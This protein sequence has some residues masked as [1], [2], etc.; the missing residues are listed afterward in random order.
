[1]IEKSA[2]TAGTSAFSDERMPEPL[3]GVSLP[4]IGLRVG[5][6]VIVSCFIVTALMAQTEMLFDPGHVPFTL[7]YLKVSLIAI[8]LIAAI[9]R[10]SINNPRIAGVSLIFA[11]YLLLCG[12]YEYFS[13]DMLASDVILG[14]NSYYFLYFVVALALQFRL[15][16]PEKT[17]LRVVLLLGAACAIVALAQIATQSPVVPTD[18]VDQN[19]SVTAYKTSYSGMRV[20]S[21]FEEP[22][23]FGLFCVFM[24]GIF[25]ALCK[26]SA[27]RLIAVPMLLLSIFLCWESDARTELLALACVVATAW[28]IT[29][30]KKPGRT[31]FLPFMWLFAGVPIGVFAY[32]RSLTSGASS[33][34]ADTTSFTQRITEWSYYLGMLKSG[35]FI[36][37]LFG[38]GL[39]QNHK[40]GNNL[41]SSLPI[42]NLFIATV[43]HIGV[44]GLAAFLWLAWE[45]WE[46]IRVEAE[47]RESALYTGVAS[48]FSVILLIGL[49]TIL[50]FPLGAF[51]LLVAVTRIDGPQPSSP[52]RQYA[53]TGLR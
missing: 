30:K 10:G 45:L 52:E 3:A 23:T 42:D 38:F 5:A 24:S 17:M 16:I 8:L 20:F 39:V 33:S 7:A 41:S 49:Y 18:S 34:I 19:F 40:I 43:L 15:N 53:G 28:I 6:I 31:R 22:A 37:I 13:L 14:F 29:F 47:T 51:L 35:D 4:F 27:T 46:K 48:V 36:R 44:I 21:L 1:M 2:I 25:T 26:K 12:L 50:S 32:I 9:F 11:G